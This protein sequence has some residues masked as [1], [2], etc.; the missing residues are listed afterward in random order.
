MIMNDTA[1]LVACRGGTVLAAS[2]KVMREKVNTMAGMACHTW[3]A[4][5]ARTVGKDDM[6]TWL[7][8][9][10]PIADCLYHARSFVPKYHWK[11]DRVICVTND[12]VSVTDT[13]RN[14]PNQNLSGSR[15]ANAQLFDLQRLTLFTNDRC[16]DLPCLCC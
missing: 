15:V 13:Y 3:L 2:A 11:W 14:D 1:M 5:A 16:C 12:D 10:H 4:Y 7:D 8:P 9:G 6:I